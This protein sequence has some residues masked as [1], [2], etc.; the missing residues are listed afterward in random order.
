MRK[1]AWD[2]MR[3]DFIKVGEDVGLVELIRTLHEAVAEDADNHVA[4]VYDKDGKALGVISMWSVMKKL[5]A[6]VFSEEVLMAHE[7][8]DWDRAFAR[9]CRACA[10]KGLEGLLEGDAIYVLPND[11][12]VI[13]V[14]TL[15]KHRRN[16]VLVKEAEQVLGVIFKS[17]IFREVSSDVLRHVQ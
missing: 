4:V 14:E 2:L 17:D 16:W 9:A 8:G 13:V 6:C 7:E 3:D 5:E 11:P 12:L 10:D 15:L 1:R